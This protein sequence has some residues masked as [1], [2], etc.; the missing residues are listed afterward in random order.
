[1][2]L[3]RKTDQPKPSSFHWRKVIKIDFERGDSHWRE[4][5]ELP[6]HDFYDGYGELKAPSVFTDLEAYGIK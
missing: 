1:M 4:V 2:D 3:D 5:D 6:S